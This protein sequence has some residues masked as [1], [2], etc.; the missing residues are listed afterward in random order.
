MPDTTVIV[1]PPQVDITVELPE[2]L[3]PS[4][5]ATTAAKHIT[6]TKIQRIP[7]TGLEAVIIDLFG[8]YEPVEK[9]TTYNQVQS[10][11]TINEDGTSQITRIIEPVSTIEYGINYEWFA[12]I[13]F[14]AIILYSFFRAIGG[15]IRWK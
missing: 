2:T 4:N 11:V 9:I 6:D 8:Q 1:N 14:F 13:F 15:V 12:G 3:T 7:P 10:L 5:T